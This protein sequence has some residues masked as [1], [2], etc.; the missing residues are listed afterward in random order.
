[1]ATK[2]GRVIRIDQN[3]WAMV[4][5]QKDDAC[6]NCESAQFC[7]S[8][9]DCSKMETRVLN[10]AGAG[11][12][13]FVA[14]SLSTA[15]VL[16]SALLLYLLPTAGLLVG[17]IAGAQFYELFGTGETAAS[18]LFGFLGL[19]LG[20]FIVRIISKQW[21]IGQKLTPVITRIL[22]PT[23]GFDL[24]KIPAGSGLR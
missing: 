8:L 16:K 23:S 1:M 7:H 6:H 11:V 24:S 4:I 2:K 5:T 19:M 10:R 9:A 17:A 22:K 18:L 14:I 12:G 21:A 3:G 20:F 13:D 15:T